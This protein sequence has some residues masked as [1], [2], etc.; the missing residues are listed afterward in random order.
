MS[1]RSSG[2]S[3]DL[4]TVRSSGICRRD[5]PRS[6]SPR[7]NRCACNPSAPNLVATLPGGQRGERADSGDSQPDQQ[8]DQT[9]PV[10]AG[11]IAG[12]LA[13][14]VI[15]NA[16]QNAADHR[17][18]ERSTPGARP[19]RPPPARR[20]CR[21]E[22][23]TSSA[24]TAS[25]IFSAAATSD[26]EVPARTS[27]GAGDHSRPQYLHTGAMRLHRG[28]DRLEQPPVPVGVDL[29]HQQFRA[30]G[31]RVPAALPDVHPLGPGRRGAGPHP[32]RVEHRDRSP[33]RLPACR[34]AATAGQSGHQTTRVRERRPAW[35]WAPFSGSARSATAMFTPVFTAVPVTVPPS[36]E[37]VF[38]TRTGVR[39]WGV[40][41]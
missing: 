17:R 1:T 13:S 18:A 24:S 14:S 6:P 35:C 2:G 21:R 27:G 19:A 26:A 11:E 9:P 37:P 29:V 40:R 7:A 31:L 23:S 10:P 30:A 36:F 15:G 25:T 32:V 28:G 16:A 12:S 41:W 34:A 4:S 3:Q 38:E 39:Q 5:S 20:R 22:H 33:A 8:V